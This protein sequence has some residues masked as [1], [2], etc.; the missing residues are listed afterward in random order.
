VLNVGQANTGVITGTAAGAR[1]MQIALKA[2]F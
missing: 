2:V 1:Q